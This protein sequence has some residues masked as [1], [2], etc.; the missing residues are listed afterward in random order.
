M[1][2]ILRSCSE[3]VLPHA[4]IGDM[5]RALVNIGYRFQWVRSSFLQAGDIVLFKACHSMLTNS[6]DRCIV[7]VAIPIASNVIF[8]SSS[9]RKGPHLEKFEH[10]KR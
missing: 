4:W 9:W 2:H 5:A 3:L 10:C 8:H 6:P 1:R 7:H